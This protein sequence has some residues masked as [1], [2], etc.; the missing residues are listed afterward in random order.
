MDA[1]KQRRDDLKVLEDLNMQYLTND[2]TSNVAGF[3]KILAPG[4]TASLADRNLYERQEYLD[5][6]A[7]PRPF[8][9]LAQ[10][11]LRINLFGDFALVHGTVTFRTRDGVLRHA[12]YTDEWQRQGGRWMCIG[13]NVT[14]DN[15]AV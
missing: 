10:S 9:E 14:A 3:E 13:A 5:L 11:D 2:Q 1:D 15:T 8:T 6:I 7:K 4:F 12:R